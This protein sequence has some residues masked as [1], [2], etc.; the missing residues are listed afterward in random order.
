M[1]FAQAIWKCSEINKKKITCGSVL[2]TFRN[3]ECVCECV[4]DTEVLK[5]QIWYKVD[6]LLATCR[7]AA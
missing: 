4:P 7:G 3:K 6:K 1:N 5:Y 2:G